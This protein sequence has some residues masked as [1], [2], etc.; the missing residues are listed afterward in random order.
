MVISLYS[1]LYT[2]ET[3]TLT[4][5]P[6]MTIE[7]YNSVVVD[8]VQQIGGRVNF[9]SSTKISIIPPRTGQNRCKL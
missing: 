3:E 6:P 1:S 7:K 9:K 5:S 4:A 8:F 2:P